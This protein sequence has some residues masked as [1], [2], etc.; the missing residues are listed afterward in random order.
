M[1]WQG[2]V[3][4]LSAWTFIGGLFLYSFKRI[5]FGDKTSPEKNEGRKSKVRD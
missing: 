5:L 2:W 3:F 4:M 1:N